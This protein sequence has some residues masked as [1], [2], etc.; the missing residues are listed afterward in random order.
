MRGFLSPCKKKI[1]KACILP[2]LYFFCYIKTQYFYFLFYTSEVLVVNMCVCN[3]VF[4][5]T[6]VHVCYLQTQ[7]IQPV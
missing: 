3:V 1:K 6:C 4:L 2:S 7:G 5:L